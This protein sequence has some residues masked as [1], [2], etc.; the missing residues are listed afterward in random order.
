VDINSDLGESF[1][2]YKIGMDEQ[3]L[4]YI[5]SAN[6]ACGFHAGDPLNM[7]KIVD[8][9]K[10]NDVKIGAHPGLLDLI[11]FGR[12]EIKITK[13]EA[14]DYTK[15]QLGALMG[16]AVASGDKVSHVK[17]HGA[18]YNMAARDKDLAMGIAEAIY[19]VDRSIILLGL[20]NSE[21][22]N[23]GKKIGLHV[24]NEVFADRAYN[25]D[26]SL[27]SRSLPG[28]VIHDSD[29]AISR[30][31]RMIKEGKV[32]TIDGTDINISADSICVHGDNPNALEFVK[33]IHE[34]LKRENIEISRLSKFIK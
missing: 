13:Q 1:G 30:V 21:M 5:S 12:R 7:A 28:S 4:K 27:V 17:P 32:E 31:I 20:A 18:L 9:C 11:G 34:T 3:I 23:A 2:V 25:R 22:I 16:F 33:K 26:G 29:I 10:L 6:I 19:E 24:A 15:Y 14:K 8:L